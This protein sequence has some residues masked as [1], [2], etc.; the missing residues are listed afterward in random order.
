VHRDEPAEDAERLI[1]AAAAGGSDV[2][3]ELDRL[4]EIA[5]RAVPTCIGASLVIHGRGPEVAVSTLRAGWLDSPVLA[6][7]SVRLPRAPTAPGGGELRIFAAAA[8]AFAQSAPWLLVLLDMTS[9]NITLDAHLERPDLARERAARDVWLGDQSVL[10][11]AIGI[12]L[13]RGLLPEEGRLELARLAALGTT[14]VLEA[15]RA[16]IESATTR[17]NPE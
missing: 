14:T 4:L 17:P 8:H 3:V 1:D 10:N 9:Q 12:L 13:D 7:L 2:L 16:L 15:A 5:V 6:S 11:R